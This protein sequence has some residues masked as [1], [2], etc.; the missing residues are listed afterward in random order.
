M[1]VMDTFSK[2][3]EVYPMKTT[4]AME[5]AKVFYSQFI[6]RHGLPV[7]I[8]S[9]NGAPLGSEFIR[10]LAKYMEINLLFTP[11]RHPES[12]G[13]VERFMRTLRQTILTYV[14]QP[15]VVTQW[16]SKLRMIRFVYS[17]NMLNQ[18]TGFSPFEIVHGRNART[19][20]VAMK[21]KN[22]PKLYRDTA[23][24]PQSNFAAALKQD[25]DAIFEHVYTK[26]STLQ[27]DQGK[28]NAL[29]VGDL[30][31]L[32]N[33]AISTKRKPRKLSMDW[34]GPM[35]VIKVNSST[36]RYDVLEHG[37]RLKKKHLNVHI[38]MLKKHHE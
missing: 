8:L 3:V 33:T 34:L 7:E 16:D 26:S 14:E 24:T 18:A 36:P 19:T 10:E 32:F 35:K 11:P 17:N 15:T 5:M 4:Q 6:T 21:D 1:V 27:D 37:T 20:Q 2:Y 25:V 13:I 31:Y 9:D 22:K 23:A 30:V 38:S 28:V 29:Q 12:N